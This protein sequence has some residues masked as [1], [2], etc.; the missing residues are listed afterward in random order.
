MFRGTYIYE[1]YFDPDSY[2]SISN[3]KKEPVTLPITES[4]SSF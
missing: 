4:V 1:M 2:R 3:F